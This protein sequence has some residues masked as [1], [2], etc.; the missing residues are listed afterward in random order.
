MRMEDMII[1]SVDDHPVEPPTMFDQHLSKEQIKLAPQYVV[2]DSGA[3]Y[4][5]WEH[6]QLKTYCVGL[7]AVVG[8]PREEYGFEPENLTQ[9]RKGAWD[10][11]AHIDDMNA[12]GML[13]S[14]NFPTYPGFAGTWFW[15]AKDKANA[16]RLISAYND[17][18][19]DE[20]CGPYPGRY[21]LT[22]IL[23]LFDMDA[24]LAEL[25]R[26]ILKGCRSVIFP[27][28]TSRLGLPSVHNAYW[29]PFWKLCNQEHIVLNCHIGTGA[30]PEHPSME[31]PISA[32]ITTMPIAIANDVAD[33]LHLDA[34]HRYPNLK[35]SLSEGGIG[36][37]PYFL[38][39]A[40]FVKKHHG[41]WVRNEWHGKLP[42]EV[43]REHFFT[44]FIDDQFG[45]RNYKDVGEDIIGYE[46]DYPHSD[47]TWPN[48]PEE[49]WPNF[50]GLSDTVIDKLTHLNAMKFFNFDPI[51]ILGRENC[52]VAALRAKATHIDTAP[53]SFKGKDARV[54]GE[55]GRPVSS[56][57]VLATLAD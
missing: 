2:E 28:N 39:R 10:K 25:K 46:C 11:D 34:L 26:L 24:T 33:L 52:T 29:E 7:N 20:W 35:I 27:G 6:E 14:V 51:A 21:I 22:G 45:C 13:A 48:G 15:K 54:I 18:Q 23:P 37:I 17:W 40:D 57:D 55:R 19:I 53:R 12:A 5:W 56:A 1:I 16:I 30:T 3:A 8:R 38:E 50:T 9:M 42:S 31:S 32:W 41:P 47:C 36:W 44:C 49:L 43:F 4:W